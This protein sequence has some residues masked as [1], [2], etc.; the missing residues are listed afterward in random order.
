MTNLAKHERKQFFTDEGCL[1]RV[2]T[3]LERNV[4]G[5]YEPIIQHIE[6][7]CPEEEEKK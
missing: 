1:V 4:S 7:E 5:T 3:V 6:L 2:R